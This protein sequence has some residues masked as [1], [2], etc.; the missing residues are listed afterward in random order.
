MADVVK[1]ETDK[2]VGILAQ[3]QEDSLGFAWHTH[4]IESAVEH[5]KTSVTLGLTSCEARDRLNHFGENLLEEAPRRG[6]LR[7]FL[8]QFADFV[9]LIL[10]GA[11]V[12]AGFFGEPED[13]I[14]IVV[15]VSLNAILGFVQEYRAERAMQALKALGA[16]NAKVI[17]SGKIESIL[18]KMIVPGDIVLLET[19]GF[20]SADLRLCETVQLK[21]EEA[22]LTGESHPVEKSTSSLTQTD[23]PIGDRRNMAYKGTITTYGRGA[24]IAVATGMRTELGRIAKLLQQEEDVK[25]PL[26]K[27]L[28]QFGQRLAVLVIVLCAVIFLVGFLRGEEPLLMFMTA[29]SLAV[30]AI[31]EALPAVVTVS[32]ALGARR[33]VMRKALIRRLPAVETLGSVT[34]I[35]SDKTGTLTQ[36]RMQ[37]VAFQLDGALVRAPLSSSV[38]SEATAKLFFQ[39]MALNNDA[40]VGES[41][42]LQGD[43]TETALFEAAQSV[44]FSKHEVE[45][46]LPRNGEIPFSSERGMMTT[47]HR[48]ADEKTFVF[49]KGGPE[50]VLS[51]CKHEW[52][53]GKLESIDLQGA[54]SRA[55]AMAKEGLR[56][57]AIAYKNLDALPA[58]LT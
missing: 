33:M 54:I 3:A 55:E 46:I 52:K 10:I 38:V 15:I 24:G 5:L 35:C 4:S 13:T 39:A 12:I 56:V 40:T 19:G 30:A 44:G 8:D 21:I 49:T 9:V 53:N 7:M 22:T 50:R 45:T 1:S 42:S 37:A 48:G 14:A 16:P 20:V 23:S 2:V 51:K 27:R 47:V 18:A 17:R 58:E 36:N 29:L 43:P 57:L 26:Q 32:L 11:A 25:T 28:A 31:P 34:Y 41:G 6:P